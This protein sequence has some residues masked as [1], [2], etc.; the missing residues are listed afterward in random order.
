MD[1]LTRSQREYLINKLN[2]I[3]N[4]ENI[5]NITKREKKHLKYLCDIDTFL[6][7]NLIELINK[8]LIENS[9]EIN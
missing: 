4:N 7:E 5:N 8:I 3:I 6:N 9:L 1:N 2:E